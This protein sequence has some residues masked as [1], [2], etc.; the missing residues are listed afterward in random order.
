MILLFN[1][2]CSCL[3]SSAAFS[4]TALSVDKTFDSQEQQRCYVS[5]RLQVK[6]IVAAFATLWK[7]LSLDGK[8]HLLQ[9]LLLAQPMLSSSFVVSRR[10]LQI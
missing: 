10:S 9:T 7:G 4:W 5:Q 1:R 6:G 2:A 8:E 3:S